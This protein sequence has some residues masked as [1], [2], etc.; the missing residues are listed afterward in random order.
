MWRSL[1]MLLLSVAVFAQTRTFSPTLRQNSPNPL[2]IAQVDG[3]FSGT[4]N[5]ANSAARTYFASSQ[6]A[7]L[8]LSPTPQAGDW[9]WRSD[10]TF[11]FIFLGG[12]ATNIA[13]WSSI[14]TYPVSSVMFLS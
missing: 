4:A 5:I 3:N 8:A 6:A 13:N 9:C 11:P 10:T 2:T 7:M 14:P 1:V 12:D